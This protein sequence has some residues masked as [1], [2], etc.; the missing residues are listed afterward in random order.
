MLR[1]SLIRRACHMSS[2]PS[3][4]SGAEAAGTFTGIQLGPLNISSISVLQNMR[5][6]ASDGSAAAPA[7]VLTGTLYNTCVPWSLHGCINHHLR[8]GVCTAAVRSGI[9]C[10]SI[11]G[12]I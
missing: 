7:Q 1:K 9:R 2:K 11:T 5:T 3:I 6:A 8:A 4:R 10:R 12:R